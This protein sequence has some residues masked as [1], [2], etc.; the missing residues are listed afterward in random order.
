M[1]RKELED[2]EL[3]EMFDEHLNFNYEFVNICGYSYEPA[4]ALKVADKVAYEEEFKGW[5]N[6]MAEDGKFTCI[7]DKYYQEF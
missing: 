6:L 2:Y 1:I 5:L 3:Y 4:H 7:D